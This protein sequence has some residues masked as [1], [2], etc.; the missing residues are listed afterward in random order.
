MIK[1]FA[2][3]CF[4]IG[5]L[6]CNAPSVLAQTTPAKFQQALS[7]LLQ[8]EQLK[9]ATVGIYVVNSK[10][11]KP[12][13]AHNEQQGLAPA[14]TLKVITAATAYELL[15]SN[16]RYRT[17]IRL[18]GSKV[19]D[20]FVGNVTIDASGDPTLG[21]FRFA[22]TSLEELSRRIV[23][24]LKQKGI[25]KLSGHL[26]INE[27]N[28]EYMA[29]PN[30]WIWEDI[31]N[32]YGAA[33]HAF[34]WHENSFNLIL[35]PGKRVG[36]SVRIVATKPEMQ[37]ISWIN[38]LLTAKAG[39]GDNAIIYLPPFAHQ[40]LVNG[41]VPAGENFF[42][43]KGAIAHPAPVFL[44]DLQQA[45]HSKGIDC[46]LEPADE[47]MEQ[48]VMPASSLEQELLTE[49]QS[50]ILDSM[51]YWFLQNSI[52]LYGEALL[53]TM[54]L[55]KSGRGTTDSG[56]ALLQKFWANQG[57]D[58]SALNIKDGSG[59]SPANRITAHSLVTVLAN[60]KGKPWFPSF[61]H[62]LPLINGIKMKSGAIQNVR[63]YTGYIKSAGGDEYCFAF[64]INN[65]HGSATAIKNKMFALL[66]VFK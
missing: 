1:A 45:L 50:P 23:A 16:F 42:T 58:L 55:Q 54:A 29:M 2:L 35:Q 4:S 12:V 46:H 51:V 24:A 37:N 38:H 15:G 3:K 44:Q 13:L 59:L 66:N 7:K 56:V 18:I 65:Y 34:N 27:S 41:T 20:G 53:K 30:G 19:G 47:V 32:Y 17:P 60:A 64:V 43:I 10:T 49:I 14:S 61:Y 31:G 33:A 26:L 48:Q 8:D 11:G 25:Q 40:A 63:S 57:L 62:G 52:N 39:S 6:A 22:A 9:H 36:D 28:W 5:L 21:S